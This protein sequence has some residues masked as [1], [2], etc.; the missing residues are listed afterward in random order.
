MP[1]TSEPDHLGQFHRNLTAGQLGKD[2]Q[3]L[4]RILNNDPSLGKTLVGPDV[5]RMTNKETNDYL[6]Q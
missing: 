2:F 5:D 6:E 3:D 4:R 1:I